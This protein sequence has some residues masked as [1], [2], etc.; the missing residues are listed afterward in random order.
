[1]ELIPKDVADKERY[2]LLSG[3]VILVLSIVALIAGIETDLFFIGLITG[4]LSIIIALN[5]IVNS[6]EKGLS[7]ADHRITQ[8][9]N[10]VSSLKKK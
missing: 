5:K 6:M 2:Y 9:E 4:I 10:Q 8:L 7:E 1:M 3:Y